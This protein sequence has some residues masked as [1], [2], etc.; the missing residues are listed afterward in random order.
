[1]ELVTKH[2]AMTTVFLALVVLGHCLLSVQG[3]TSDNDH[4]YITNAENVFH[5]KVFLQL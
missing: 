3:E 4:V 5:M 1:M 2:V